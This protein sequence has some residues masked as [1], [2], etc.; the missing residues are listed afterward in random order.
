MLLTIPKVL[1]TSQLAIRPS[2]CPL[3]GILLERAIKPGPVPL[4]AEQISRAFGIKIPLL[5][6]RHGTLLTFVGWTALTVDT[7]I[8]GV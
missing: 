8:W 3:V 6:T 2:T 4:I 1:S 5:I 7:V